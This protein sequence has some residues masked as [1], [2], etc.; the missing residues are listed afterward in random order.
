MDERLG[1]VETAERG[2]HVVASVRGEIDLSN[3]E[4]IEKALDAATEGR[5]G[6][7]DVDLSHT[8]YVDSTGIRML[9]ALA[10]R[11]RAR[12]QELRLVV[13]PSGLVRRVLELTDLPRVIPTVT[14]P[15]DP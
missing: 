9:F 3:V 12:R 11:L 14:A 6:R 8:T 7:Y 13:P 1:W 10:E 5:R 2:G 15:E 4:E